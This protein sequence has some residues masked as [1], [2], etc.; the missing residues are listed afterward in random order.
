[1]DTLSALP[2]PLSS[3]LVTEQLS[4]LDPGQVL[5]LLHMS[6]QLLAQG[7]AGNPFGG[8]PLAA[9]GDVPLIETVLRQVPPRRMAEFVDALAPSWGGKGASYAVAIFDQMPT[10][11]RRM[12]LE[13]IK[14]NLS[15]QEQFGILSSELTEQERGVL[16]QRLERREQARSIA[17]FAPE[18]SNKASQAPEDAG[19]Q[20]ELTVD[21]AIV[22]A[23]R[24]GQAA[25][26]P[27]DRTNSFHR[28][29]SRDV[30]RQENQLHLDDVC[31]MIG[32]IIEAK[33]ASDELAERSGDQR[34][35]WA[36]FVYIWCIQ[37]HRVR[38]QATVVLGALLDAS[39][40]GAAGHHRLRLF[41]TL[42]GLAAPFDISPPRVDACLSFLAACF[43]G[44][45]HARLARAW[46]PALAPN[47]KG[48][49][50]V[51]VEE[52]LQAIRNPHLN[53]RRRELLDY[54]DRTQDDAEMVNVDDFLCHLSAVQ[55]SMHLV[56]RQWALLAPPSSSRRVFGPSAAQKHQY[57]LEQLFRH[58]DDDGDGV[59]T[60]DE[61][62][63]LCA[64]LNPT[65]PDD[66][67]GALFVDVQ[68]ASEAINPLVGDAL[69]PKA[70]VAV[71]L[72]S[73]ELIDTPAFIE[74]VQDVHII[75]MAAADG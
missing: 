25:W 64:R 8:D 67:V 19:A 70:F 21:E 51:T 2:P 73:P 32:A 11:D 4:L 69:H 20:E 75:P 34:T 63:R 3:T 22:I 26:V 40:R 46:V 52:A 18:T 16:R 14:S 12:V 33:I 36:Q 35:G 62:A 37:Q 13:N 58:S 72:Q 50:Q 5:D 1:M 27:L 71:G 23:D 49:T 15:A 30:V 39:V 7:R 17:G 65:L 57:A 74:F 59:L 9:I 44:E 55:A 45:V 53:T 56:R 38:S 47:R 42:C 66:H 41:C 29:A 60:V 10:T 68:E 28:F 31:S 6:L 48:A 61:F 43:P 24:Q 54:A